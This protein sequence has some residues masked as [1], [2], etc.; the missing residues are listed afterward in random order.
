VELT[1]LARDALGDDLGVLVD[2]DR[3]VSSPPS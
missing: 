1:G 2:V 3:H